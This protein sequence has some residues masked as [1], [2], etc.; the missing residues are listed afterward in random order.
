MY[1]LG[2]VSIS[3][4]YL[5]LNSRG[6]L[7]YVLIFDLDSRIIL[8]YTLLN[9][10]N[11][12][13]LNYMIFGTA[14]SFVII[15]V[16][17][18]IAYI[19]IN[20]SYLRIKNYRVVDANEYF[21][22][23]EIH[24]LRQI[25]FLL[26]MAGCFTFVVLALVVENYDLIYL[27]IY[28]FVISLICF[29]EVDTSSYKGKLIAFLLIPFGTVSFLISDF[30]ILSLFTFSHIIAMVYMIKV[31][32]GKFNEYTRNHGLGIAIL[33]LFAIVFISMY[34][35]SF[36]EGV[37]MLDAL[38][39]SSNAFTSNGYAVLGNSVPGKLDS[40]VLVWGGYLLSGVSVST[41][42]AAILMK[43]FD[44]KF[45]DYDNRFDELENL[46]KEY[47]K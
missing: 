34:I 22:E 7:R 32:Y 38:V 23:D 42:T 36:V 16:I 4:I 17:F 14:L 10:N 41:L 11:V 12:M 26:M 45:K 29:I 35:T 31:Y 8:L 30:S 9:K 15:L 19:F 39:M 1:S 21:P 25:Y 40:L 37:N 6:H 20:K 28:D 47:K 43:Y 46:L 24:I 2:G 18:L 33:L 5:Y 27:A 13:D 44:R 3:S